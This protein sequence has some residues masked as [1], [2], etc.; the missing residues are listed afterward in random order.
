MVKKALFF[1][2]D[3]LIASILIISV[4]IVVPFFYPVKSSE[5]QEIYFASDMVQVLSSIRL[6]EVNR[7]E[8]I[9]LLSSQNIT[10]YNKTILEQVLRFQVEGKEDA[11][12]HLLNLTASSLI[13]DYFSM[14]VWVEGYDDPLFTS[15][16]RSVSELASSKQM[17]S[18]IERG[19][20]IEGLASRVLLSNI[21]SMSGRGYSYFGG[22]EGDGNI[23]KKLALPRSITSIDSAYM[24]MDAGSAFDLY[25]NGAF[26]GT[27]IPTGT[28]AAAKWDI[29]SPYLPNFSPGNNTILLAFNSSKKYVGGGYIR[30][31]YISSEISLTNETRGKYE[32]PG[33]DGIINIYSSIFVPG[34]LDALKIFLHYRSDYEIFLTIGGQTIYSY[35]SE[36]ENSVNI[37]DDELK[38]ELNYSSMGDTTIPIRLGLRN[39]TMAFGGKSDSALI[40]DRTGSMETCD[41]GSNCTSGICDTYAPCHD[42]RDRVA[43]KSDRAFVNEILSV[44]GNKIGLVGYGE[45]LNSV[46]S[47]LD[48]TSD[49]SSIQ[50]SIN[51]YYNQWCGYTCISC[52]ITA[53]TQLLTDNMLLYGSIL[54][55]DE[56]KTQFHLGDSGAVSITEAMDAELNR[57]SFIKAELS[58]FGKDIATDAGYRDCVFFNNRYLGRVC[59]TSS[60][61]STGWHTCNYALKPEYFPDLNSSSYSWLLSAQED[62]DNAY[63]TRIDTANIS[64]SVVLNKSQL[65]EI[66]VLFNDTFDDGNY[67]GWTRSGGNWAIR[68]S[69]GNSWQTG[70]NGIFRQLQNSYNTRATAGNQ[71]WQDYTL[72]ADIRVNDADPLG[73]YFRYN[74]TG[75]YRFELADGN[76]YYGFRLY[77]NSGS[78]TLIATD[79]SWDASRGVWYK[80]KIHV[81]GSNIKCYFDKG[82]GFEL[83]FDITDSSRTK[84]NIGIYSSNSQYADFDNVNVT[85][86]APLTGI[87]LSPVFDSGQLSDWNILSWTQL[88]MDNTNM[89]LEL[90]T[91][92]NE[93][94]NASWYNYA[95]GIAPSSEQTAQNTT[96]TIGRNLSGYTGRYAQWR[97]VLST[98][99]KNTT[100][101]LNDVLLNYSVNTRT[102]FVTI[103]AGNTLSCSDPSGEND[104]WDLK[105]VKLKVYESTADISVASFASASQVDLDDGQESRTTSFDTGID[106]L[107]LKSAYLSFEAYGSNPSYYNCIFVNNQFITR[108]DHQYFS[109]DNIWQNITLTLPKIAMESSTFSIKVTSGTTNGCIQTSGD[110]DAWSYRNLNLTVRWNNQSSG[111][112]RFM[113][114]LVMSDGEANTR[115][116]QRSTYDIAGARTEASTKACEA[117]NK[118]GIHIY[119]VAFGDGGDKALMRNISCCEDCSH[120]YNASNAEELLSVYKEIARQIIK[121]QYQA[122]VVNVTGNISTT[123][124]PDSFI[125]YNYT[126]ASQQKVYGRI[127]MTLE[128]PRMDNNITEGSFLVPSNVNIK[129]ARITSYSSDKWTD[130]AMINKAGEWVAFYNLS[131]Y[132]YT[133]HPL[134][135]PYIIDIPASLVG[136]GINQVRISTGINPLNSTGG[137]PDD[138]VIYTIEADLDVN[139]TG[140]FGKAEGCRWT[141]DFED[142]SQAT[143]P[144]PDAYTGA[145]E[146]TFSNETDCADEFSDDAINNALCYL[147]KQ[148]DF[149]NN[150]KLFTK[151]GEHDLDIETY[152]V[153]KKIPYMWGPTVFE[154]RVWR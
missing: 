116:G 48:F 78:D 64:G 22:Y 44:Q 85:S 16:N 124:F 36:G 3:A 8:V 128:T 29:N 151:F 49:N 66:Q 135:D 4:L 30:V 138:R 77:R 123:L 54:K 126:P 70:E 122:Q 125:E 119:S 98:G 38:L 82:S 139:Y 152:S 9:A 5:P 61:G 26:S 137:S 84:G 97:A 95:F 120:Y 140:I 88:L 113:S 129:D 42:R 52:G 150:G 133:Y 90:R 46:C 80:I 147:F 51:D 115:I 91:G 53:A 148:L 18:G 89:T 110:N 96:S 83:I 31:D 72:Q 1:S 75:Y 6:Q 100:P 15:G 68:D 7:S 99:S 106:P 104:D 107:E 12:E 103:T 142:D 27:Y 17:V 50:Q 86:A 143:I 108:L 111:Y 71:S 69:N 87:V 2:L 130:K 74:S 131:D 59:T 76:P 25:I 58:I 33:V 39:V 136:E 11:A 13:P 114:M 81:E 94:P 21:N 32:F 73:L 141:L 149:D 109:G 47:T 34:S 102:N 144:I 146:C 67:V 62:F 57:S 45:R 65:A 14:G 63:L 37:T 40:T 19:R 24:E 121:L 132:G 35:S 28:M 20:I 154:V 105:D 93:V 79:Y 127:P 117:Y 134:G 23:T 145:E 153:G 43:Q 55:S 118:Y 60:D 56:N 10:D 112:N 92:N 101:L 41:V